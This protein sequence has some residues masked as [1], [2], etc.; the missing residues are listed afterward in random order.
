MFLSSG[1]SVSGSKDRIIPRNFRNLADNPD[2]MTSKSI[3]E[4][5]VEAYNEYMAGHNAYLFNGPEAD[6]SEMDEEYVYL[7]NRNSGSLAKYEIA[8]GEIV[9]E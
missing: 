3:F 4:K 5:A 6:V 2:T 9:E 1:G 7:A 8:T